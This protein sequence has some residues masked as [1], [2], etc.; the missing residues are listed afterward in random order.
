MK[1]SQ[2]TKYEHF[3]HDFA[4]KHQAELAEAI[5]FMK[6]AGYPAKDVDE[7]ELHML[8]SAYITAIFEPVLHGYPE[9]KI[10]KHL[11]TIDAFFMPGWLNIMGLS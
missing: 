2:G 7:E 5:R 6:Q 11:A 1:C 4:Y 3:L 9:E 8:L 10:E